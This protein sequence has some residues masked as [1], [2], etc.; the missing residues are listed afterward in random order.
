MTQNAHVSNN[1]Q[2]VVRVEHAA[3]THWVNTEWSL[4]ITAI[5]DI[6]EEPTMYFKAR[7]LSIIV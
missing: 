6:F 4:I 1:V 7:H 3:V 2:S 5:M